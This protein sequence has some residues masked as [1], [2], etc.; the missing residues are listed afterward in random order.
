MNLSILSFKHLSI[1]D[2]RHWIVTIHKV[3]KR[4]KQIPKSYWIPVITIA[5]TILY[6]VFPTNN[7]SVDAYYSVTGLYSK[8]DTLIT[9][10]NQIYTDCVEYPGILSR[11]GVIDTGEDDYYE[12]NQG[13]IPAR[14]HSFTAFQ[15][16]NYSLFDFN[17][18]PNLNF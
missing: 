14:L 17:Q 5:F 6:L 18:Y 1:Q 16:S 11:Q 8:L 12:H 7:S 3:V 15:P 2:L 10:E 4:Q 9:R 13:D